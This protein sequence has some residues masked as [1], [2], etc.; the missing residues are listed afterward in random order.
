METLT[1]A[2]ERA[3]FVPGSTDKA[4]R[5]ARRV[6]SKPRRRMGPEEVWDRLGLKR[7]SSWEERGG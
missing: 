2:E 1:Y 6:W 7:K 3:D 4:L 5:Q